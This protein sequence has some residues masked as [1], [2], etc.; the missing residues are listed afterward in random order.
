PG[1]EV[2][3]RDLD[4]LL[5]NRVVPD[6]LSV[7]SV[8]ELRAEHVQLHRA[9][10]AGFVSVDVGWADVRPDR[11]EVRW[12]VER[13]DLLNNRA[14]RAADHAYLSVGPRLGGKPFD[15]IIAV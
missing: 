4:R 15:R 2:F 8:E 1:A 11:G 13:G 12:A 10:L 14:V 5:G 3:H 6:L 7:V 9:A